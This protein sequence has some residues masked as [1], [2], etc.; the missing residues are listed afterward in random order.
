MCITVLNFEHHSIAKLLLGG[1]YA[2]AAADGHMKI[3]SDLVDEAQS[4]GSELGGLIIRYGKS[5]FFFSLC[6]ISKNLQ[7]REILTQLFCQ[8]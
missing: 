5:S 4:H 7:N 8:I 3:L 2:S 1:G 6:A